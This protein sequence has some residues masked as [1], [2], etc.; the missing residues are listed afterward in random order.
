MFQKILLHNWTV[1]FATG[2]ASVNFSVSI[3]HENDKPDPL[4]F[5]RQHAE[6]I[7]SQKLERPPW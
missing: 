6:Y 5:L 7:D 1:K 2:I 3:H 4:S